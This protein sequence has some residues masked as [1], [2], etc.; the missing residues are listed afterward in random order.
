M[1]MKKSIIIIAVLLS[2]IST[3]IVAQENVVFFQV[4]KENYLQ[5][6]NFVPN[7][8]FECYSTVSG[9]KLMRN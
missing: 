8:L 7:T 6:E 3:K 5:F 2:C 4:E 9:G 1:S